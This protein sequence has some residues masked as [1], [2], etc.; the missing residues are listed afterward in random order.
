MTLWYRFIVWHILSHRFCFPFI[1]F[2]AFHVNSVPKLVN[3]V[4]GISI[5]KF[6]WPTIWIWSFHKMKAFEH[7]FDVVA[8]LVSCEYLC[9][10]FK[11]GWPYCTK[12]TYCFAHS[13]LLWKDWKYMRKAEAMVLH[14]CLEFYVLCI[15]SSGSYFWEHMTIHLRHLVFLF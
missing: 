14:N 11:W 2:S 1:T 3:S 5:V 7:A 15:F 8:Y 4:I 6:V 10:S 9:C 13:F 12:M